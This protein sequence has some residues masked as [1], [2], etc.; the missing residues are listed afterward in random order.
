[1]CRIQQLVI[2]QFRNI[3][4]QEIDLE[5]L[6]MHL[7]WGG[8]GAGK[9]SL[10]E[11]IYTLSTGKSWR[12]NQITQLIQHE[13]TGF[14]VSAKIVDS[15]GQK[16][17]IMMQKH[18]S[19]R[20]VIT[21]DNNTCS[22]GELA[23]QLPAQLIGTHSYR[24]FTDG[25]KLRRSFF[26]WG[27]FHV[28]PSFHVSWQHWQKL[29]K[30]RNASLKKHSHPQEVHAWDIPIVELSEKIDT[31]RRSQHTDIKELFSKYLLRLNHSCELDIRYERGWPEESSLLDSLRS[32]Y[33]RD[34]MLGYTRLGPQKADFQVFYKDQPASQVLSQGQQKLA[35]VALH[36]AQVDY[37]KQHTGK[38]AI[39]LL[40]DLTAELDDHAQHSL[41]KILQEL[42]SQT[43]ITCIDPSFLAGVEGGLDGKLYQVESGEISCKVEEI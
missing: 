29:L 21:L 34:C 25:P 14:A 8:N 24:F 4:E 16:K 41:L 43:L 7:F 26:N 42:D 6:L 36:L 18:R 3:E 12:S 27:L 1:M 11:A 5:G 20:S 13:K 30:Q 32:S 22:L 17:E 28:E 15:T 35:M 31:L 9:S 2:R 38:S 19:G 39:V 23:K 37:L 10:L 33:K 40:D